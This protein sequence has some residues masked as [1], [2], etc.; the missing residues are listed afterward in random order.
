MPSKNYVSVNINSR[1]SSLIEIINLFNIHDRRINDKEYQCFV[2]AYIWY[3][4][5][6][7]CVVW[8]IVGCSTPV[9]NISY[10]RLP[11][12]T[13]SGRKVAFK[14]VERSFLREMYRSQV[15]FPNTRGRK[16]VGGRFFQI[17]QVAGRFKKALRSEVASKKPRGRRSFLTLWEPHTCAGRWRTY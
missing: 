11:Q 5:E 16:S 3:L 17:L 8:L 15:V 13:P 7:Y 6:L 2:D 4:Y 1:E 14:F 12:G 9:A 10:M